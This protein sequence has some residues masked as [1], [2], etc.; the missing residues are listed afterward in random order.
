MRSVFFATAL[1]MLGG[2]VV[3]WMVYRSLSRSPAAI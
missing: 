2:A 3:N 1:L